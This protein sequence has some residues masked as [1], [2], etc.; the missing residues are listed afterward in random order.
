MCSERGRACWSVCLFVCLLVFALFV[1][2][3]LCLFACL[4]ACLLVWVWGGSV[5]VRPRGLRR[6]STLAVHVGSCQPRIVRTSSDPSEP[7]T[8]KPFSTRLLPAYPVECTPLQQLLRCNK[9][10]LCLVH[11]GPELLEVGS[12]N[13]QP[14]PEKK[15]GPHAGCTDV[16]GS[17]RESPAGAF[18]V[19]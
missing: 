5:L 2:F 17:S 16:R 6:P 9:K 7:G 19:V 15:N 11:L 4:L 8:T 14:V 12:T 3:F 1:P 10:K 18:E 13:L